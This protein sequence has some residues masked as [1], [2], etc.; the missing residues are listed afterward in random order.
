MSYVII[1]LI[2]SKQAVRSVHTGKVTKFIILNKDSK[3]TK[4]LI[5]FWVC[6]WCTLFSHGSKTNSLE[7]ILFFCFG[8]DI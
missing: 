1:A 8:W 5:D 3:N 4:I 2:Y 7:S 6:S